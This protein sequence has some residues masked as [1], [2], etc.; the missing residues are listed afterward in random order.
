MY[1]WV[2]REV[3]D[4]LD[5]LGAVGAERDVLLR[6]IDMDGPP[7]DDV[8]AELRS[9]ARPPLSQ[10]LLTVQ[11]RV[12]E[13]ENHDLTAAEWSAMTQGLRST[14]HGG[15]SLSRADLLVLSA[16]AQWGEYERLKAV[17]ATNP[18][19]WDY[20]DQCLA[21]NLVT[22]RD[23][24]APDRVAFWAHNGHVS[25]LP[26][27]AGRRLADQENI[28]YRAIGV[29]F[30]AGSFIAWEPRAGAY[31]RRLVP[32]T[33]QAPPAGS[34]EALLQHAKL[35]DCVIDLRAMRHARSPLAEPLIMREVGL[36][37]AG[38]QFVAPRLITASFDILV[39]IEE[40][41]PASVIRGPQATW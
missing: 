19:P 39:W 36:A 3:L 34:L 12:A 20:R 23:I 7:P 11:E 10:A 18:T 27:R 15:A 22:Q 40:L 30:G 5:W 6:G 37:A 8:I 41:S 2:Y 24:T 4:L 16:I 14:A 9:N 32:V 21:D 1:P 38:S 17:N 26:A 28:T 13:S 35:E 31:S 33:A 29:A 25:T